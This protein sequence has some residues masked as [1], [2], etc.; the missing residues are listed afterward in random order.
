MDRKDNFLKIKHL[1]SRAGFGIS[2]PELE[3]LSKKSSSK[4]LEHFFPKD[5]K[6]EDLTTVSIDDSRSQMMMQSALAGKK[7]LTPEEKEQRKNIVRLQ[8]ERSRDLNI[9]WLRRMMATDDPFLEKMTL[10]WHGHF[11]CRTNDP[12]YAQQLNNIQRSHAL[13][14]F[15]T[16]LVEVSKSPAMLQYLNNQQN[17]KNHPNENFARELMELFT[18]GRGNYTEQDIKESARAFTGW[19]YTKEGAFEFKPAIHDT[20]SKTF[21]GKTGNFDGEAIIDMILENPKTASFISRK[22]YTFFVNDI[23]NDAHV[24]ELATFM[25]QKQYNISEVMLKL[26]SSDWFYAPENV[27]T[28]IK[29][30]IEFI[31]GLSREFYVTYS[32]PQVL[33]Q[34][35]SSLGQY[36]FNPPNVAG[37]PGGRSW[38]DSSSLMLRMKIPSLVLNGG[39]IDFSGKADPEDEAL[40]AL[41]KKPKVA[42]P[43]RS[44]VNAQADWDKFLA[45]FPKELK[46]TE[47]AAYLLQPHLNTKFEAMVSNSQSLKHAAVEITSMPEYQLC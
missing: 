17:R 38:I 35:Q 32:R 3:K 6:P 34:L 22:L 15:K 45:D 42:A 1:Y 39:V 10:F 19:T 28:K 11:A 23:P 26:F 27:G 25:Y 36:L 46:P 43:V 33:I 31:V 5:R 40:I 12:F 47:L 14:D 4:A 20:G 29:S 8:N 16:L 21:F 9:D 13:G 37:W 7:D 24:A 18:I 2:Y 44:Y 41:N 30:P